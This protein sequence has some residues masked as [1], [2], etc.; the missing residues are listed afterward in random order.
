MGE[1]DPEQSG[2]DERTEWERHVPQDVRDELDRGETAE[3]EPTEPAPEE[4]EAQDEARRRE[5][6]TARKLLGGSEAEVA[7]LVDE[8]AKVREQHRQSTSRAAVEHLGLPPEQVDVL[9]GSG[10]SSSEVKQI[11]ALLKNARPADAER[12]IAS[13]KAGR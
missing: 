8:A 3:S 1:S 5:L 7:P 4:Q 12:L 9:V 11:G 13:I 6:V 2:A 10:L